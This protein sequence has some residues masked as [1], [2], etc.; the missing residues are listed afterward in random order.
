MG[1]KQKVSDEKIKSFI[2]L[3]D[4]HATGAIAAIEAYHRAH[5]QFLTAGSIKNRPETPV[6]IA[7]KDLTK[8]YKVGRQN[9][10]V[11]KGIS[12]EIHEGEF[13]ALTG[14]SGSGKSTLLQLMGGLDKVTSGTITV[15]GVNI[16][17]LRDKK[18]STFRGQTIGFV[19][20]FFYLQP[21]LRLRK[22]LEVPGMFAR[23]RSKERQSR[24]EMLANAVGLH[25]RLD[26][27]PKELSGGQ[28]QRAAIARALL[29]QPKLLFADEP[30]GNLDSANS[31]AIIE[32]FDQI[33]KEFGTTIVI[34]THD[35]SIADHAD[36]EIRLSD[37]VLI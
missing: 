32:L 20:Q 2:D 5:E 18:L 34:V 14:P 37:G 23:I 9:L 1:G 16:G 27:Y 19:F 17:K 21:F 13:V 24:I 8:N 3:F 36:R 11:L 12:L 28:M 30:T 6:V 4:D 10:E 22:N 7:V 33:R 25:D 26:H 29:N 31:K 15:D 35:R